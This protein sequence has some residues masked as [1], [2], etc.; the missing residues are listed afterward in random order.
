MSEES[1]LL[2]L[3]EHI[4][5]VAKETGAT[6]VEALATKETELEAEAEMAQVSSVNQKSGTNIAIRLYLNKQMGSAFTNIPTKKAVKEAVELA[7]AAAKV[8][9]EDK[10]W[11]DLPKPTPYADIK[12]LWDDAITKSDSSQVVTTTADLIAQSTAAE[13][14]LIPAYA[15]SGAIEFYAAYANSNGVA[16]SEKGS[17]AWLVLGAIAQ[18]ESGVTPMAF[19]FDIQRGPNLDMDYVVDDIAS[20]IKTIK[21]TATAKTG[22]SIV[23]MHPFA[24]SQILNYTLIQSIRG[25]NVA[26]GKSLIGDKIG[27]KIAHEAVTLVDDGTHPKGLASSVADDEGVPRQRT[28][29]IENGVLRSFIW[30][31]YWANRMGVKSTGNAKRNKRQGLVEISPSNIVIAP[32]ERDISTILSEIKHG[33]YIRGVQGAHSSNPESGDFSIVGNPAILIEDGKMVGAVH[34]LMVSGNTFELLKQVQ[35]I[36]KTPL[37]LQSWIGPEIVFKDISIV[38]KE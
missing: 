8:T 23:V 11:V 32:G 14:G 10:D 9:T 7:F 1:K 12:G 19:S 26:R 18:I 33:F 30:D 21:K 6:A 28:P 29:I 15:S 31:T 25:D 4:V 36:A 24:Y 2:D 16:H 20:T 35:E 34:G 27:E 3:C 13:E 17:A 38:A 5:S 22:K 37:N